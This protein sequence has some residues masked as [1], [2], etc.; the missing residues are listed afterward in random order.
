[1]NEEAT[2]AIT[3][4]VKEH[5]KLM[6][7]LGIAMVILGVLSMMAPLV[8]GV[9][10]A[11]LV[12][13]LLTAAGIARS[14]LAF[15]A[16]SFGKGV[17]SFLI[18]G[19]TVLCGLVMLGRPLFGLT[20]LTLVLVAYFLA[21]GFAEIVFAFRARPAKGWVWTLVGGIVSVL[22]AVLIW[23]QWPV[24]GTWAIGLLVGIKLL[25]A[26]WAV[27]ALGAATGSVA[28]DAESAAAE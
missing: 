4:A 24:S 7:V 26:G 3:R 18:G 16:G 11:V 21:D 5:A 6:S 12:G 9:A 23:R 10:V 27:V 8:T 22:L 1:M 14:V 13:V 28:G 19:L 20:S 2:S 25:F 17:L 15:K